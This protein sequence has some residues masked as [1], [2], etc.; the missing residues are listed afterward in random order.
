MK[1]NVF[2]MTADERAIAVEMCYER[3]CRDAVRFFREQF[4]N[5]KRSY[6]GH[7]CQPATSLGQTWVVGVHSKNALTVY[8]GNKTDWTPTTTVLGSSNDWPALLQAFADIH[9][10]CKRTI[11]DE[12]KCL[13]CG[14][15]LDE[16]GECPDCGG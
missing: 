10:R 13:K 4:Q 15:M 8:L 12:P 16:I 14:A 5:G 1:T 6:R 11:S 3:D 7:E 9:C 2:D